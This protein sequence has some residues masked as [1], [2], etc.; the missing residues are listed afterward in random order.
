MKTHKENNKTIMPPYPRLGEVYRKLAVALNTKTANRTI[1]RFAREG[2]YNWE[3]LASSVKEITYTPLKKYIGD[4]FAEY[5][6]TAAQELH[7]EYIGCVMGISLEHLTREEAL[8]VLEEIIF[9]PFATHFIYQFNEDFEKID[10]SQFLTCESPIDFVITWI[11]QDLGENLLSTAYPFSSGKDKQQKDKIGRWRTS[12]ELP[13]LQSIKLFVDNLLSSKKIS[14]EKIDTLKY[15]LVLARA[16]TFFEKE[17][18]NPIRQK[19]LRYALS[20]F[21]IDS[22]LKD[23][24]NK[25]KAAGQKNQQLVNQIQWF[26]ENLNCD[27]KKEQGAQSQIKNALE[28][29]RNDLKSQRKEHLYAFY[30]SWFEA[31]WHALSENFSKSLTFYKGAV[32]DA[33]Y[34]VGDAEKEIVKEALV[35]AALCKEKSFLKQLKH[36]AIAFKWLKE[37]DKNQEVIE[38]WEIELLSNQLNYIFPFHARFA[39][40]RSEGSIAPILVAIQQAGG[41]GQFECLNVLLQYPH[42]RE[43]LNTITEKKKLSPLH[44][45]IEYCLPDVVEKLLFMGAD[46]N[47]RADVDDLTPL[48]YAMEQYHSL[49][50]QT[51]VTKQ[52]LANPRHNL[53][54]QDALRRFGVSSAGVFGENAPFNNIPDDQK[55]SLLCVAI[56]LVQKGSLSEITTIIQ[57]LL[58]VG[59]DPN[60]KHDNP[61]NSIKGRTPLM[62]T[63]E[64]N[65]GELFSLMLKHGG[66]VE[67]KDGDGCNCL[68]LAIEFGASEIVKLIC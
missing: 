10:M 21:P 18:A 8:P 51:G 54:Q 41:S 49:K 35:I 67:Q 34:R 22:K 11:E 37:S 42:K 6:Y 13:S 47:L 57:H 5:I 3:A 29:F 48:Y 31:R 15:W 16:I 33:S 66:D 53:H 27:Q 44:C 39:E 30:A 63:I 59:A 17:S 58:K 28:Q 55:E 19:M 23:L 7:D 25:N 56:S 1:D 65:A 32:R 20:G 14:P 12:K 61:Q 4:E 43:T 2:E 36:K 50:N 52:L 46:P 24:I 38:E 40:T 45:A 62:S 68:Q 60:A 64:S 9:I 26:F